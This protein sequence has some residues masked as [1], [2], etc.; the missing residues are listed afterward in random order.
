MYFK[1]VK[2]RVFKK[3]KS[4]LFIIRYALTNNKREIFKNI[5]YKS[6]YKVVLQASCE[7]K[8]SCWNDK[9]IKG[10]HIGLHAHE[11]FRKELFVNSSREE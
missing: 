1:K 4:I 8:M 2:I 3:V 9:L 11:G 5:L 10:D 6:S 7:L